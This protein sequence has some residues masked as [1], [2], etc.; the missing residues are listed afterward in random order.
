MILFLLR[1]F[2][3]IDKLTEKKEIFCANGKKDKILKST[4]ARCSDLKEKK[5]K[6]KGHKKQRVQ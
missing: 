3:H 4:H 2:V 5:R 1:F 6:N